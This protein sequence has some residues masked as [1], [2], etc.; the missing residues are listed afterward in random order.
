MDPSTPVL[1]GPDTTAPLRVLLPGDSVWTRPEEG[2]EFG[3]HAIAAVEHTTNLRQ[4][5]EMR[6]GRSFVCSINH[7]ICVRGLWRRADSLQPGEEMDGQP[8]GIVARVTYLGE[9]PVV[10]LTIPSARTYYGADGLWQHN[11]VKN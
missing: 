9:G 6:D 1:I 3:Y 8:S 4:M 2:G 5:V 11:V 10:K 7:L